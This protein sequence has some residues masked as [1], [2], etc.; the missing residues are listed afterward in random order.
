[1]IWYHECPFSLKMSRVL[2]KWLPS[3]GDHI[4]NI[5]V[6]ASRRGIKPSTS[7]LFS[8]IIT[9]LLT[10]HSRHLDFW[11]VLSTD[12][13]NSLTLRATH[14]S[15]LQVATTFAIG[16][17]FVSISSFISTISPISQFCIFSFHF[18]LFWSVY[19]TSF[20]HLLQNSL[21]KCCIC[22]QC[23]LQYI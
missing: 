3:R 16:H 15:S 12:P 21:D 7:S 22:P 23:F 2:Y 8:A 6:P 5:Y 10:G 20:L 17:L 13:I 18:F 11:L 14:L 1:M 9:N 4:E 19:S